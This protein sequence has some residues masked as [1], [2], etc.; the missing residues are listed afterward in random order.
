[1]AASR[2]S[3]Q[4]SGN[5]PKD[6]NILAAENALDFSAKEKHF[7]GGLVEEIIAFLGT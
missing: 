4:S 2:L 1:M 7:C 6:K 5:T 3:S